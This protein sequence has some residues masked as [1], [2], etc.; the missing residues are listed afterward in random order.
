MIFKLLNPV[1]IGRA[2]SSSFRGE[3]DWEALDQGND[4]YDP[5]SQGGRE[6]ENKLGQY[7]PKSPTTLVNRP[8]TEKCVDLSHLCYPEE[9]QSADNSNIFKGSSWL[10]NQRRTSG[11]D[12]LQIFDKEHQPSSGT[13][14]MSYNQFGLNRVTSYANVL[15]NKKVE[16]RESVPTFT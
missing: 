2:G 16:F 11:W 8:I 7:K 10:D 5:D 12:R 14:T 3:I 1:L 6:R 15:G 4:L 9:L 13:R